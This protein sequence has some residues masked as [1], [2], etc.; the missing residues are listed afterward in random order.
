M[1][2]KEVFIFSV[3]L[4][5]SGC[6]TPQVTQPSGDPVD[7]RG[8]QKIELIVTDSVNT[9]YSKNGLP[10]FAGLLRGRLQSIGYALVDTA[11]QMILEVSV[12]E[13]DPGNRPLRTLIGFGAG[14][15]VLKYT[16]RFK[17]PM[18]KLLAE[19]EGGK[20]YHGLELVDNPTFKSDEATRMGLITY[21]VSQ[22]GEFIEKNGGRE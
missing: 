2:V 20:A 12:H 14:R 16:A 22:I 21:S 1:T 9:A 17:T 18:G 13:F 6:V 10:M 15:A 7:W 5:L 8:F 19:L 4:L 11:P 3:A